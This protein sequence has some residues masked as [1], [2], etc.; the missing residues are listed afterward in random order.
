MAKRGSWATR[1]GFYLAA[2]GSGCGLGNLWRFPY[3]V[4]EN[5]G[6]AFVLLYVLLVL[7]IGLPLLVGELMLGKHTGKSVISALASLN[8][9]RK[10]WFLQVGRASLILCLVVLSYY[11]LISGWVLH[12]AMQFLTALLGLH[13]AVDLSPL[14]S[15]LKNGLLQAALASVH[16]IF[17]IVVVL[18]GVQEGLER[19]IG[20]MMPAFGMLLLI[21]M[22]KSLSLPSSQE[23][24]RF[25][26][27]PDFTRL[28]LSSLG[29][30]VGH[31]FFTLSVGFGTIV[32]FGSYMKENEHIPTAGV[33]VALVDTLISMTA[34]MLIFP[35]ALQASN[36][37]LTDPGLLFEALPRFLSEMPGGVVFGFAFFVC[38]YMAALASSIGLMEV[39][40]SN[41]VD[42]Q[43]YSRQK[44]SWL[45]GGFALFL[46]LI[47]AFSSMVLRQVNLKEQG[48]LARVD[49]LVINWVLPVIAMFMAIAISRGMKQS[50]KESHFIDRNRAESGSL[51]NPWKKI[52]LYGVPGAISLGL[53][54]QLIDLF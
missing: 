36:I 13:Q 7:L 19:V 26:F 14:S 6:G 46:G 31:V 16:L 29:H 8:P 17:C 4:G 45:T 9:S 48:L 37:P 22:F 42:R 3:I 50:E 40:V 49:S 35:I 25:F 27:Y 38:L 2:I 5:G 47:P 28:S 33:R 10:S 1:L 15:L 41:L 12:F 51:Y 30:A 23:A 32:T 44:A 52:L 54:L 39:I 11:A 53:L 21:L 34:G 24:I 43:N 20:W 18:K